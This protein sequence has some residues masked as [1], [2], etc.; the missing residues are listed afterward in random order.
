MRKFPMCTPLCTFSA[1]HYMFYI[2][3]SG[4]NSRT[5]KISSSGFEHF[6]VSWR[7]KKMYQ[8]QSARSTYF[9]IDIFQTR[10]IRHI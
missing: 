8:I 3:L 2:F 4:Y 7:Q 9:K 1:F 10:P 5:I 6:L